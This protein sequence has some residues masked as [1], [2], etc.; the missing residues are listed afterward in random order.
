MNGFTLKKAFKQKSY[1][2]F[3]ESNLIFKR[4][5]NSNM[6]NHFFVSKG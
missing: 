2:N 1:F 6:G 4:A 3:I 5:E